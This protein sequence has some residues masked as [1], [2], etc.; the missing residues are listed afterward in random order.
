MLFSSSL[1]AIVGVGEEP[2]LSPRCLCLFNTTSGTAL[3]EL[4]FLTSIL[5]VR[6]NRKSFKVPKLCST[7]I[8]L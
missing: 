7:S 6:M 3:L 8:R 5:S 1:L 4:N 2:S